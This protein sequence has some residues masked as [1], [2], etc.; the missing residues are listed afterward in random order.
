MHPRFTTAESN[1]KAIRPR[2]E[3]AFTDL[4]LPYIPS[5]EG[6]SVAALRKRQTEMYNREILFSTKV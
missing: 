3:A 6:T 5:L 1:P 2:P 4:A